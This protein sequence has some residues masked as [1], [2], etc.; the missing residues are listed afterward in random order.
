MAETMPD[1]PDASEYKELFIGLGFSWYA[2]TVMIRNGR[3]RQ[4]A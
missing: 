1:L 2:V 3:T 4:P